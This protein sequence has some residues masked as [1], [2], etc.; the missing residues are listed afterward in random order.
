MNTW[1]ALWVKA[2][3]CK[4]KNMWQLDWRCL[5]QLELWGISSFT[6]WQKGETDQE[7]LEGIVSKSLTEATPR[8]Q[9]LLI[10]IHTYH[11]D[12]KYIKAISNQLALEL[13]RLGPIDC[14][15]MHSIMEQAISKLQQVGKIQ[16]C[17][18]PRCWGCGVLNM[19]CSKD[20]QALCKRWHEEL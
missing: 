8:L 7:T 4:R 13:S 1:Y 5:L 19:L 9:W 14:H 2:C 10:K 18:T 17:K 11:L 3:K 6:L 12:L 16:T 15:T 20:G